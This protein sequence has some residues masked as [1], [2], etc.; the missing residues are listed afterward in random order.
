MKAGLGTLA[1][2]TLIYGLGEVASR[3]VAFLL[4]PVFTA[5]LSPSD[6]GVI[7]I[8]GGLSIFLTPVFSLGIGGGIAPSYFDGNNIDRKKKTIST[9]FLLVLTSAAA[10]VAVG[11]RFAPDISTVLLQTSRFSPL[12]RLSIVSTA[13][14]IATIPLR[15]SL[16]FEERARLYVILSTISIVATSALSVVMI[17]GL[18]RG[19]SGMLEAALIGQAITFGLF[20]IPCLSWL[21]LR[22]DRAIARE[23][24]T[25]SLPL[26]PAFGCMFI[27]QHGSKYLLQWLVGL[28]DVGVYTVGMNIGL[29]VSVAV[30]AFQGAWIPYFMSFAD[31]PEEAAVVFG[32]VLTYYAFAIGA[33]GLALFAVAKPLI[34]VMTAPAFHDAWRVVG[35]SATAQLIAGAVIVLLPGMYMAKQVQ[36]IGV[37]QAL[38]GAIGI[39]INLILIRLFGVFGAALALVLTYLVLAMLQYGWNRY[40]RYLHVE[41]EWRRI[42]RFA[43]CY[44]AFAGVALWSRELSL[45]AEFVRSAILMAVA[46]ALIYFQLSV[47]ERRSLQVIVRGWLGVGQIDQRANL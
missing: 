30:S 45:R 4:L 41:Y 29:I 17:V 15:Q 22:G 32:R 39:L 36:F 20:A 3:L 16:Q 24:L 7:S 18:K 31:R 1:R 33:V 6:Y 47:H 26:V 40:R 5:Y 23:L 38:A 34:I 9:S 25:L 13:F 35:L 14:S 46:P 42:G 44:S 10:L 2:G 27:L 37:I 11:L 21:R 28:D 8:L 19:V 43:L 12:V